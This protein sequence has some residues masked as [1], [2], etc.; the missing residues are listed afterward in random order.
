MTAVWIGRVSFQPRS[1]V[2][3]SSRWSS[4][5][6]ANGTGVVSTSIGWS[7]GALD[8]AGRDDGPWEGLPEPPRARPRPPPRGPRLLE[9]VWVVFEFKL[10][11]A[12]VRGR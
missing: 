1:R 10:F 3:S 12:S 7:A 9:P 8:A 11:L 2:P 5:S 6:E 4:P